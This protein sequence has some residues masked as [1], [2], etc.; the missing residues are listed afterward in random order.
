MPRP[1]RLSAL[2]LL[3]GALLDPRRA[4]AVPIDVD[5]WYEAVVSGVGNFATA[6]IAAVCVPGTGTVFAGD[7]AWTFTVPTGGQTLIV[8]DGFDYGDILEVFDFGVSIGTTSAVVPTAGNCGGNPASCVTDPLSSSGLF[9]MAPGAHSITIQLDQEF[10][11]NSGGALFFQVS[12]E[13]LPEPSALA[14]AGLSALGLGLRRLRRAPRAARGARGTAV[15]T[16]ADQRP[17]SQ[18]RDRGDP[19]ATS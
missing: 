10:I 5:V 11:G 19:A 18:E 17:S 12:S 13:A 2:V 9:A 1:S 15:L 7:P 8:T 3:L 6:C 4:E 16:R 14:L